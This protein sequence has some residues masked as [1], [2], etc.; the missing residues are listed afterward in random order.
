MAA[1]PKSTE[2]ILT[3]AAGKIIISNPTID[4]TEPKIQ[5]VFFITI[6]LRYFEDES[7]LKYYF[8]FRNRRLLCQ[9]NKFT[10]I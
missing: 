3:Q 4:I 5:F 10:I 1:K 8:K 6:L 2:T 9:Q 7:L